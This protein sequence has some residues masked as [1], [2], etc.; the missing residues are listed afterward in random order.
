MIRRIL[1]IPELSGM[2]PNACGY[3]RMIYPLA[4]V[5]KNSR[6]SIVDLST[7]LAEN[8]LIGEFDWSEI[9]AVSTQRTAPMQS[10]L[11]WDILVSAKEKGIPIHWDLDDMPFQLDERSHESNYLSLLA[12]T[13]L[14]MR[15]FASIVTVSTAQIHSE[16]APHFSHVETYRNALVEGLW[17][18]STNENPK[19]ILY[20]GLEAHR[21]G[22]EIISDK[23]YKRNFKELKN[24]NFQIDAV[25]PLGSN[26]HPM[27]RIISVPN[28]AT[29]YP[30]FASWLSDKHK[31]SI[32]VVYHLSSSFNKGKSAIKALEYSSLGL[33]TLS[34]VN[35]S[36]SDDPISEYISMVPD[37]DFIDEML[38][39]FQD[40]PSQ[41]LRSRL[42]QE[43]VLNN[44]LLTND[45]SSMSA[46][47]SAF[48]KSL[49]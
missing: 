46:F 8:K 37:D 47:Y 29:T 7:S 28:S 39:L 24:I 3:I 2:V 15:N 25:G 10:R 38:R 44:R 6:L 41:E 4:T 43:Y 9:S 14:E 33:T 30:R 22:L 1:I 13:A 34:N 20:F 45:T 36:M 35:Q 17:S 23:L 31:S 40:K 48:V 12:R 11:A 19:S 27:I 5:Q 21:Q 32:G 26:Y 16:V 49:P 18:P 42:A